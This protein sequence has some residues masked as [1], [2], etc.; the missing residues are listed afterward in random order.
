MFGLLIIFLLA[1]KS[2]RPR[3][4]FQESKKTFICFIYLFQKICKPLSNSNI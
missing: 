4:E 3:K 1:G 2:E